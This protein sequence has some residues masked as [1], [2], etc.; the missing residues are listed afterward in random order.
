LGKLNSFLRVEVARSKKGINLSP[1][2]Y[3]LDILEETGLLGAR[4][5][6]TPMDPNHKLLRDEGHLFPDSSRYH[7]LV[8]KLNYLT[9]TRLDI[10]YAVSV[11]SQFVEALK[12][13]HWHIVIRIIQY[14]KRSPS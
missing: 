3:V 12:L 8:G 1:R 11:V 9:I 7:Q 10:S 4:P 13:S 14:L 2:K 6:D 5:V